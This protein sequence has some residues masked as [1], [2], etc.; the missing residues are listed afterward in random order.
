MSK[1]L[2][3][4]KIVVD[5]LTKGKNSVF[6]KLPDP[7]GRSFSRL[8]R[9]PKIIR[10]F[11]IAGLIILVF[12]INTI[13]TLIAPIALSYEDISERQALEKQLQELEA[14]I[15]EYQ[16]NI[17]VLQKQANSL[18]QTIKLLDA[19]IN[20]LNL[21]IKATNLQLQ[22][23]DSEIG[24]IKV[25][26]TKTQKDIDETQDMLV[27]AL[28]RIYEEGQ[29]TLLVVFLSENTLSDAFTAV[30]DL[31]S[32]QTQIKNNLEQLVNLKTALV[33]QKENL[34]NERE[35]VLRLK[36]L[37]E[38]QKRQLEATKKE[39]DDL[40]R[41]TK[42]Q[43]SRYQE[44]LKKTQQTASQIRS[45]IFSLLGGGEL[46]FEDAYKL[47]KFAGDQTRVR[48]ALLLAV[49]DRESAFGR[50]VGRCNWK[51]A[52]HP[53]RDQ[54]IFLQIVQ[55]LGISPD[56]VYV[57]CAN[58]DGAYGGAMGPAQFI[59][60]TW[61]QY[62]NRIA[63]IT[64][65][66]PP[67]PWRNVDAFVAMALLLKDLGADKQTYAAEREAAAR[68][69][70]GS[71]WRSFLYSYGQWVVEKAQKYEADIRNSNLGIFKLDKEL[72]MIRN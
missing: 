28:K 23:L 29:K 17:A 64:G 36:S 39:K 26:V 40:M 30:N 24:T 32:L 69:Y 9:L 33:E 14:Q 59:P 1:N 15:D 19:Q 41:I 71:R 21:Q 53:T 42:G 68:Y 16:G 52:M 38:V 56:S 50:N 70:A 8:Y 20:K 13:P 34:T 65:N 61:W 57:S 12:S 54:P 6:D 72:A 47:A 44:L 45:R 25:N 48:P 37:Q 11:F 67:S 31:T 62:K 49:L 7:L 18:S 3:K 58:S 51:T 22:K 43:E 5:V 55:E 27:Y 60:S 35:E 46:S 10:H 63:A 66:N 2:D 4:P